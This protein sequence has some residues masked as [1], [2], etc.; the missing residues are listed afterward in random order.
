MPTLAENDHSADFFL[1]EFLQRFLPDKESL[2]SLLDSRD[3][4]RDRRLNLEITLALL[5]NMVRPGERVG[6][7][8]EII[9]KSSK[10]RWPVNNFSG[11]GTENPNPVVSALYF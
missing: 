7:Q 2:A 3:F 6:Y 1:P 8:P 11:L 10:M 9:S 5:L 4:S